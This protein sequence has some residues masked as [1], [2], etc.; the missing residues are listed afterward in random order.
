[1]KVGISL[2][3]TWLP[4][5]S[6]S[7]HQGRQA[8][9]WSMSGVFRR[10]RQVELHVTLVG[11]GGVHFDS[12]RKRSL[13]RVTAQFASDQ[14]TFNFTP[15]LNMVVKQCHKNSFI[16]LAVQPHSPFDFGT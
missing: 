3:F 4:S 7:S 15:P 5:S 11:G 8:H 9:T 13:G 2:V 1:M 16:Y 14:N 6:S 10:H 12:G